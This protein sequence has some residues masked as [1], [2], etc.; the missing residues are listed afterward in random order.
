MALDDALKALLH[1]SRSFQR[2]GL[3]RLQLPNEPDIVAHLIL[4]LRFGGAT[5]GDEVEAPSAA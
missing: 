3:Q 5:T 1:R 2:L 4:A